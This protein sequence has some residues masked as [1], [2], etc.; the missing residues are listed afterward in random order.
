MEILREALDLDQESDCISY[1]FAVS[2]VVCVL[3]YLWFVQVFQHY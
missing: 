1:A 2:T 3:N